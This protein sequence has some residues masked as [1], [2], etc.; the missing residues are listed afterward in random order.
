MMPLFLH[1][2]GRILLPTARHIWDYLLAEEIEPHAF[3]TGYAAAEAF[4]GALKAAQLQGRYLYE[5]LVHQYQG[6]LRR[7]REKGEYAFI[8]RRRSLERIGLPAVRAHRLKQ[9]DVEQR[10]W[11]EGIEKKSD[12]TPDL[13]ALLLTRVD[14]PCP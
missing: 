12:I 7:E 9:L 5:G 4:D 13:L 8:A 1:D 3:I 11:R 2:D 10:A 6:R 14:R